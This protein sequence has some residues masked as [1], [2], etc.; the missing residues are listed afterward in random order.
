MTNKGALK[1]TASG[2]KIHPTDQ[3]RAD[4]SDFKDGGQH[5]EAERLQDEVDAAIAAIDGSTQRALVA[6]GREATKFAQREPHVN[7]RVSG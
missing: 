3:D 7:S 4:E 1:G 5:I 6:I 2:D